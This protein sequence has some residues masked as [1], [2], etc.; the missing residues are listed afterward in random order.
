[1]TNRRLRKISSLVDVFDYKDVLFHLKLLPLNSFF[2]NNDRES[3]TDFIITEGAIIFI[4]I[5]YLEKTVLSIDIIPLSELLEISCKFKKYSTSEM[6]FLS[7]KTNNHENFEI[8]LFRFSNYRKKI[9]NVINILKKKKHKLKIND[10]LSI[11]D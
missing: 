1:M 8:M 2:K 7:F 4:D 6:P 11:G 10:L 9:R 5:Y 3:R